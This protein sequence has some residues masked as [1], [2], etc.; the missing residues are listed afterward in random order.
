MFCSG[1][2]QDLYPV[3]LRR[4]IAPEYK[5]PRK[6]SC[7]GLVNRIYLITLA[8]FAEVCHAEAMRRLILA[9]FAQSAED[10]HEQRRKIRK[11]LEDL[12]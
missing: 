6:L 11:H 4:R 2:N 12:L 10:E 1:R 7:A 9:L 3:F 8:L 5:N